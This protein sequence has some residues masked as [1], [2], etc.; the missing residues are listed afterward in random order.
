MQL[1]ASGHSHA[2]VVLSLGY[3]GAGDL[4][5]AGEYTM[6]ALAADPGKP[7][8]LKNLDMELRDIEPAQKHSQKVLKMERAL[9]G[10][11][12]RRW[13]CCASCTPA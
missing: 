12:S 7:V 6:Q 4:P 2:C 10:R 11:A 8:D 9:P 13:S 5:R 1:L 3:Q